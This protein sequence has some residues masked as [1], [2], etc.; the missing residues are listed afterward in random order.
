MSL[1]VAICTYNRA[2]RLPHLVA[3]LRAQDCPVPFEILVVDNNS[4]DR[5]PEVLAELAAA[6]APLRWVRETRQGITFARNRAIEECLESEFMAFI[7]DDELPN[8]GWLRSAWHALE[9]EGAECVGGRIRVTLAPEERPRWLDQELLGFLGELDHGDAAF[10]IADSST[11]VWS[12]NVAYRTA[13]FT[14]GELRF[15]SRFNRAGNGIGG[16]EDAAMF[17]VLLARGVKIR[18]R[19]DMAITHLIEPWKLRRGYFLR[20]HFLAGSKMGQYDGMEYARS[21]LGVPPFMV[22]QALRQWHRA[23]AMWLRDEPGALRQAMNGTHALG[24][25]WG[26]LLRWKA[27]AG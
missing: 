25:I 15:D 9:R 10:W 7:D 4:N 21:L 14:S 24:C 23:L 1:S 11:P 12:G 13:L 27:R 18:Y 17:R 8:P 16:G 22:A 6:G 20:L 2:E 19:P 5:T 3:A 26:R